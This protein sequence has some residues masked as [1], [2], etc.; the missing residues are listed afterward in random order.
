MFLLFLFFCIV[1]ISSYYNIPVA[2]FTGDPA[3]IN[4]GHPFIGIL[5]NIG[6]LI[7]SFT[8]AICLFSSVILLK[9]KKTEASIFLL[10][11]SL[12]TMFLLLDDLFMFHERIFPQ[13]L[14]IPQKTVYSG[15]L[16]TII[17]Y[18][19][20][21]RKFI[22]L[23]TEYIVLFLACGFFGLSILYDMIMP[24]SHDSINYLIEDGLKFYGITTWF[25]FFVRTSYIQ[26]S[27][28][29]FN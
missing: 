9:N 14:H 1:S 24:Q 3:L 13:Y 15:Y 5:S 22:I 2:N 28:S 20:K 17:L 16:I 25:I 19:I 23:K 6:I 8:V 26:V 11:S 29:T 4:G 12:L 10:F 18:F 27:K 7:W 21:F